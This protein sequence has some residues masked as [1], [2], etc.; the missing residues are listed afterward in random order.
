MRQ[1]YRFVQGLAPNKLDSSRVIDF[2]TF[3]AVERKVAK[4]TQNQAF[5]SM[6]FF[7]VTR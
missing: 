6:L 2:L 7:T 4:S 3:L 5:C 1:F